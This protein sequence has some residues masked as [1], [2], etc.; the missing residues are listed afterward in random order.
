MFDLTLKILKNNRVLVRNPLTGE[1]QTMKATQVL[2][3]VEKVLEGLIEA[4]MKQEEKV[5]A[6]KAEA[7]ER[8]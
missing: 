2:D 7:E 4:D 8:E 6:I 3:H 1:S 5:A